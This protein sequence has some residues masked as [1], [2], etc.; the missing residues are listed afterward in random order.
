MKFPYKLARAHKRPIIISL[1]PFVCIMVPVQLTNN[2]I[3]QQHNYQLPFLT[4]LAVLEP[5]CTLH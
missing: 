5:K 2:S 4:K 3:L 1:A